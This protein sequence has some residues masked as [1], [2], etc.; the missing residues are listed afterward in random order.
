MLGASRQEPPERINFESKAYVEQMRELDPIRDFARTI[1]L[2]TI[3]LSPTY[4]VIEKFDDVSGEADTASI[5]HYHGAAKRIAAVAPGD[6]KRHLQAIVHPEGRVGDG[7]QL[8]SVLL[9]GKTLHQWEDW[10][11]KEPTPENFADSIEY[12]DALADWHSLK[13]HFEQLRELVIG[14]QETRPGLDSYAQSVE[15]RQ[16]KPQFIKKEDAPKPAAE[17]W[18]SRL[19]GFRDRL[20][21]TFK[22]TEQAPQPQ[23]PEI[24]A[25]HE[26]QEGALLQTAR[27]SFIELEKK[28]ARLKKNPTKH[29]REALDGARNILLDQNLTQE[30]REERFMARLAY[31]GFPSDQAEAMLAMEKGRV[32]YREAKLNLAKAIRSQL[33][34]T[35]V[36]LSIQAAEVYKEAIEKEN[37]RFNAARMEAW[38]PQDRRR[39]MQWLMNAYRTWSRVHPSIRVALT[40]TLFG[41]ATGGFSTMGLMGAARRFTAGSIGVTTAKI[42]KKGVDFLE[43]REVEKLKDVAAKKGIGAFSSEN[44]LTAEAIEGLEQEQARIAEETETIR[45]RAL[46]LRVLATAL[47]GLVTGY[48][49]NEA[50]KAHGLGLDF[51]E[52][53]PAQSG[54]QTVDAAPTEPTAPAK[55]VDVAAAPRPAP[56][57]P[58]DSLT[59]KAT[60]GAP[61]AAPGQSAG[62]EVPA[63]SGSS[64]NPTN[65]LAGKAEVGAVSDG[66]QGGTETRMETDVSIESRSANSL[67]TKAETAAN[68]ATAKYIAKIVAEHPATWKESWYEAASVA[69]PGDGASQ[70]LIRELQARLEHG[71]T[72]LAK[73]LHLNAEDLKDA[74]KIRAAVQTETYR[75]LKQD[76]FIG[77]KG[78]T[79]KWLDR[80]GMRVYRGADGHIHFEDGKLMDPIA[81][82][83][84]TSVATEEVSAKTEAPSGTEES[85]PVGDDLRDVRVGE[86]FDKMSWN[87]QPGNAIELGGHMHTIT[88]EDI[89]L[90]RALWKVQFDPFHNKETFQGFFAD[91]DKSKEVLA[92]IE[93]RELRPS[94]PPV[95]TYSIVSTD[96]RLGAKDLAIV[97][98]ALPTEMIAGSD[99]AM[100]SKISAYDFIDYINPKNE[101]SLDFSRAIHALHLSTGYL[102]DHSIAE[103]FAEHGKEL[104]FAYEH[105]SW[106]ATKEGLSFAKKLGCDDLSEQYAL[107]E[108]TVDRFVSKV[109]RDHELWDSLIKKGDKI[110]LPESTTELKV[111]KAYLT[112]GEKILAAREGLAKLGLDVESKG[113]TI[114]RLFANPTAAREIM[115]K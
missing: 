112:L 64:G 55:S 95:E 49:V 73:S 109:P 42:I 39:G 87:H 44:E 7:I 24:P 31:G 65:S 38:P 6:I 35:G 113:L 66:S 111:N 74:A 41:F 115:G 26:S 114:G 36:A 3:D 90:H 57:P 62:A 69:K 85:L 67:T 29:E 93:S 98:K 14:I 71:D 17:S 53:T 52:A 107:S 13:T 83:A 100:I 40:A 8:V 45:Q 91:S 5:D 23:A 1:N 51:G 110:G 92:A 101:G 104:R 56:A 50:F 105:N 46:V 60:V 21:G 47:T 72:D 63:D 94:V 89:S 81:A 9:G 20:S 86:F 97:T 68:E 19:K 80:P 79:L 78:E 10:I 28:V 25:E 75:L 15:N 103:V 18:S 34:K 70:V 4:E 2:K 58:V 30:E 48:G 12:R 106:F 16:I 22:K 11:Q 27:I 43:K 82:K 54:K 59:G 76:G 88:E 32:A 33:E 102:K 108:L 61:P 77:E 37:L 96:A 99:V 84:T